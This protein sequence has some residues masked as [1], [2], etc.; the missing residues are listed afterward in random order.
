MSSLV[1]RASRHARLS[2]RASGFPELGTPPFLILFIN[3]ICN[4]KCEHCFYWQRLNSRIGTPFGPV[5]KATF[6]L[7]R[8]PPS[9][10]KGIPSSVI[11]K[12]I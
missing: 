9:P 6:S 1:S 10:K 5:V 12:T 3:S 2:L 8:F 11:R 7:P 4:L